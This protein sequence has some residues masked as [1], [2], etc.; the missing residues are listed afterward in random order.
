MNDMGR[1]T[2][3]AVAYVSGSFLAMSQSIITKQKWSS[4]HHFIFFKPAGEGTKY[5]RSNGCERSTRDR[6]LLKR[7][8]KEELATF[9]G[10]CLRDQWNNSSLCFGPIIE[11]QVIVSS[12]HTLSRLSD[13]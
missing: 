7:D 11:M 13:P 9:K 8:A 3:E 12:F 5:D 4:V 6:V 2:W 1:N 10:G